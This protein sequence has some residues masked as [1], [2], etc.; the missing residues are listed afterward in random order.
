MDDIEL[1]P[2]RPYR[3]PLS[4]VAKVQ[5]YEPVNCRLANPVLKEQSQIEG[6]FEAVNCGRGWRSRPSFSARF[7]YPLA[8]TSRS[9]R[10]SP[11]ANREWYLRILAGKILT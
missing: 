5:L 11:L 9:D 6:D 3:M 7:F 2:S 1:R 10:A 8:P 4:E